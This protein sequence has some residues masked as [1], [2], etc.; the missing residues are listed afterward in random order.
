MK[1]SSEKYGKKQG[2]SMQNGSQLGHWKYEKNDPEM[3]T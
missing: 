1:K 3:S 2:F